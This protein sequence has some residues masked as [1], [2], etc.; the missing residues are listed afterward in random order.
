MLHR[1]VLAFAVVV[2]VGTAQ[3]LLM[4]SYLGA[5]GERV[6]FVASKPIVGV[7]QARAAWSAYRD[8]QI[9]LAEALDMIQNR[10]ERE[11]ITSFE[12]RV[13][14][15]DEHIRQLVGAMTAI[16][17]REKLETLATDVLLWKEHARVLLGSTPSLSIPTPHLLTQIESAI[18]T[19]LETIVASALKEAGAVTSEVQQSVS[20]GRRVSV[21][22]IVVCVVA[23]LGLALLLSLA[24]TRPLMR[25]QYAM[26]EIA[27][28][29]LE[30]EVGA[31]NRTDEIGGMAAALEIFRANT[32]EMKRLD[33]VNA[34]ANEKLLNQRMQL[35]TAMS[36]MRQGLVMFGAD[37]RLLISNHR[38]AEMYG[39]SPQSVQPGMTLLELLRLR[40]AAGTFEGSAEQYA[41]TLFLKGNAVSH[42]LDLPDG[43]AI[44]VASERMEGGGW[45]ATHE[46]IT[47]RKTAEAKIEYM[48]HHDA[49][50]GLPNRTAFKNRMKQCLGRV[51]RG[52]QLALHCL[53]LDRFKFVNDM[54]GHA[55]GDALLQEVSRRFANC[56]RDVDSVARLGGDEF[57]VLQESVWWTGRCRCH[58]L[59]ALSMPSA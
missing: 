38:Y 55:V 15:L 29:N 32:I 8:A 24:I 27:S 59:N 23:G 19:D 39:L 10:D 6:S 43:R 46:D 47:E 45:V 52:Q 35:Q 25:L 22:L 18:R 50:T 41:A 20:T 54:L 4:L 58:L 33:L 57:V 26:R 5:L 37:Q 13:A 14:V 49:L 12:S 30:V 21:I 1:L 44:S 7:D 16:P 51:K 31:K 40:A 48:A 56:L 34:E 3:G 28:G 53:D 11:L 17:A 9:S 42:V 36:N 2:A